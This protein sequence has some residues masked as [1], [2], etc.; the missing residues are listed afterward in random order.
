L[1]VRHAIELH[2]VLAFEVR[3]N[4]DGG[5]RTLRVLGE[6]EMHCPFCGRPLLGKFDPG[7][8][9]WRVTLR[10]GDC[11]SHVAIRAAAGPNVTLPGPV[12]P[13]GH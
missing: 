1:S 3:V 13:S 5:F 8:N 12:G 11:G 4:G 10:C 6:V 2:D 9:Y 7:I